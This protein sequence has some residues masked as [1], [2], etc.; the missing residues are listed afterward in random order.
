[1]WPDECIAPRRSKQVGP[2]YL[3]VRAPRPIAEAG[4]DLSMAGGAGGGEPL[5]RSV[6]VYGDVPELPQHVKQHGL[7]GADLTLDENYM[8]GH[9]LVDCR[10]AASLG[11]GHSVAM[12]AP[13]GILRPIRSPRSRFPTC[14]ARQC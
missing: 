9:R 3:A 2:I 6:D 12:G 11:T 5:D 7:A 1:M 8:F 13:T 10:L 4:D 14:E